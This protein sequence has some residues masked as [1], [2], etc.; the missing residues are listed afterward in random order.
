VGLQVTFILGNRQNTEI[1]RVGQDGNNYLFQSSEKYPLLSEIEPV[2]PACFGP[3][4][5]P[6][7]IEELRTLSL[8]LDRRDATQHIESIIAIAVRCRDED[9][10]M[11][12]GTP[13]GDVDRRKRHASASLRPNATAK[14]L[15]E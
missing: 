6:E 13:F 2:D 7:L 14:D 1:A 9:G 12:I 15:K 4:D 11:L 8:E 10:M 3:E 5:M